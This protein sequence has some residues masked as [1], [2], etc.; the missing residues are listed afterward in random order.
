VSAV[1]NRT[2]VLGAAEE[3]FEL[4]VT[5]AAPCAFWE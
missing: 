1:A 2:L 4:E 3:R 5:D